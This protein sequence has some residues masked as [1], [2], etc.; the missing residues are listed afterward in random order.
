MLTEPQGQAGA[1]PSPAGSD[2]PWGS[3]VCGACG[4]LLPHGEA[5]FPGPLW[6]LLGSRPRIWGQVVKDLSSQEPLVSAVP[7]TQG[8]WEWVSP[9]GLQGKDRKVETGQ[10]RFQEFPRTAP[11][12]HVG[13]K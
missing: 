12:G 8:P 5:L 13:G 9:Q 2:G 11:W 6:G 1:I 4:L 3:V 7:L 10:V